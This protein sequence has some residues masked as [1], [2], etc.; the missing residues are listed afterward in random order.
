M[1]VLSTRPQ[2]TGL[3]GE[4]SAESGSGQRRPTC[5]LGQARGETQTSL[6]VLAGGSTRKNQFPLNPLPDLTIANNIPQSFRWLIL[7]RAGL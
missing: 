5:R 4:G 3:S 6:M 2:G 1:E 7:L